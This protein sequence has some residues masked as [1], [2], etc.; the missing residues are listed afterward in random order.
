MIEIESLCNMVTKE[1]CDVSLLEDLR[2]V[3]SLYQPGSIVTCAQHIAFGFVYTA[4]IELHGQN[5]QS[6]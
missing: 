4:V 2:L 3:H 5:I 6:S 1:R